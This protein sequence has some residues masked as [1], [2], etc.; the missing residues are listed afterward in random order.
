MFDHIG[1]AVGLLGLALCFTAQR[2]MKNSWRVGIDEKNRTDLVETGLYRYIRNPTYLGL[3]HLCIGTWF[4]WPTWT[5]GLFALVF[6]LALE[7][8]VRCEED[9]LLKMHASIREYTIFWGTCAGNEGHSG[10]YRSEIFDFMLRGEMRIVKFNISRE[11]FSISRA[12]RICP[13]R[14]RT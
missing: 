10:R 3:Y 5:I 11:Q 7:T 14:R 13:S 1:F 12:R 6:Y 4:I 9:F 2:Q 8:Q